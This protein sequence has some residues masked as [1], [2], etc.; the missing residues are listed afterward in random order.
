MP[1]FDC[2]T[3]FQSDEKGASASLRNACKKCGRTKEAH[4]GRQLTSNEKAK[5]FLEKSGWSKTSFAHMAENV[6]TAYIE[7]EDK[8]R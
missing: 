6:L 2:P 4:E 1:L 5:Y 8:F 3:Y 7:W